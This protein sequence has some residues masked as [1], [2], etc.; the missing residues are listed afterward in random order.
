MNL[1]VSL[2]YLLLYCF[3]LNFGYWFLKKEVVF[4]ILF[5]KLSK[6]VW[7]VY[8]WWLLC[9][10]GWEDMVDFMKI[11]IVYVWMGVW[12]ILYWLFVMYCV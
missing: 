2:L 8:V 11:S 5:V 10:L 12:L 6:I 3:C 1:N 4:E 9:M 7:F